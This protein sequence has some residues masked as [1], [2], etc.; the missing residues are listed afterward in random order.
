MKQSMKFCARRFIQWARKDGIPSRA[1]A[2]VNISFVS[3]RGEVGWGNTVKGLK[4][5]R[6]VARVWH[7]GGGGV[8]REKDN[9]VR[10]WTRK[11]IFFPVC[12]RLYVVHLKPGNSWIKSSWELNSYVAPL[13][14]PTL[15]NAQIWLPLEYKEKELDGS[16]DWTS[17]TAGRSNV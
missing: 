4:K 16:A 3:W 7:G 6:Y 10:W 11:M 15:G 5:E 13:T 14:Q 17:D 12:W 9:T 1:E 2:E 8:S